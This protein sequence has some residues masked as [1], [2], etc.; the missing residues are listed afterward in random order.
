MA[1]PTEYNDELLKKAQEYRDNLPKDESVHS[2]EGLAS[3]IG[4]SRGTIYNWESQGANKEFL[5]IVEEIREK[6]AKTLVSKGL[7]GEFNSSI[8]KVMLSKHGY[9]EK[10]EIDHTTKGEK[11]DN[12]GAIA[13]LTKKLN[14]LHR[15]PSVSGDGESSSVVGTEAQY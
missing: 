12:S 3:Y 8:T 7:I 4:L 13:E 9:S 5:D 14:D 10:T 6:Q 1:R 11:I 15:S 2:I